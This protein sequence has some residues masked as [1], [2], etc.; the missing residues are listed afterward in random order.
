MTQE[1]NGM[2]VWDAPLVAHRF[3]RISNLRADPFEKASVRN[4]SF[5][6]QQWAF[7]RAY[8]LVPAQGV[9]GRLL[10]SF[11]EYPPRSKPASF[12][13]GHALSRLQTGSH[14]K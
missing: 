12:S 3:P 5:A 8:L 4:A 7:R 2:D 10:A 9:V 6:W 11:K 14:D 1:Q 13:V